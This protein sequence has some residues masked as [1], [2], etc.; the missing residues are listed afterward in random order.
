MPTALAKAEAGESLNY[1]LNICYPMY[2]YVSICNKKE[3]K[4]S[5]DFF[6]VVV[7][8]SPTEFF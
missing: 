2:K 8:L 3:M 7:V 5:A 4:M 1:V 6:V